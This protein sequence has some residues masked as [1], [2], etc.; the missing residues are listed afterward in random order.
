MI[1]KT[2]NTMNKEEI[3][4]TNRMVIDSGFIIL[5]AEDIGA[6]VRISAIDGIVQVVHRFPLLESYRSFIKYSDRIILFPGRNG[7][8]CEYSEKSD[9]ST[10]KEDLKGLVEDENWSGNYIVSN[11]EVYFYW[12]A[13]FIIKYNL[14]TDKWIKIDNWFNLLSKQELQFK[15][16]EKRAFFCDDCIFF[17]LSEANSFIKL[18]ITNNKASLQ[19]LNI[20][21]N[22]KTQG[23]VCQN[24]E[25]WL[26]AVTSDNELIVLKSD[27][28][29]SN[30]EEICRFSMKRSINKPRFIL[31][32]YSDM[33]YLI[34]ENYDKAF[35]V[36]V[37]K[38]NI[39]TLDD[40]RTLGI[41]KLKE[42]GK[43]PCN[44]FCCVSD[45]NLLY[46]I[47][48][49]LGVLAI[50]DMKTS[51]VRN[52]TLL[53]SDEQKRMLLWDNNKR[54]VSEGDMF[55]LSDYIDMITE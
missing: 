52:I 54:V 10:Y 30:I 24:R 28:M 29:F 45:N 39:K 17:L 14:E 19:K 43:Y 27:I 2:K 53:F 22:I 13:P 16:F 40:V 7:K 51:E 36:N 41:N 23:V 26:E 34:P 25:I 42:A 49:K 20:P 1:L 33:L 5:M 31:E 32:K 18:N 37:S 47:N 9:T 35:V 12:D 11:N 15:G 6:L 4:K 50:I 3:F 21:H 38:K 44:Y 46:T 48:I 55:D 8:V